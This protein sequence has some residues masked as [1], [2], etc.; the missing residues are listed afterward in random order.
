[1]IDGRGR[2]LLVT[3]EAARLGTNVHPLPALRS[4]LDSW[5]GIGAVRVGMHR[6]G[7]DLQL[8]RLARDLL[9]DGRGALADERHR[10][11]VGDD[12]LASGSG[13]G[14]GR[15]EEGRPRW[16]GRGV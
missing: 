11:G 13:G 12:A 2:L 7:Y 4:W 9:R 16:L 10:V 14:A 5:P 8:T 6:Q 1:M 3:L 15:A